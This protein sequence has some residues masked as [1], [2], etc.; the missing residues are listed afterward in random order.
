MKKVTEGEY[1]KAKAIINAYV[2]QLEDELYYR[3]IGINTSM[4]LIKDLDIS[5]RGLNILLKTA[6]RL[7]TGIDLHKIRDTFKVHDLRYMRVSDLKITLGSSNLIVE[8]IKQA[9]LEKGITLT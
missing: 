9:F 4:S 5:V 2:K 7:H 3:N 6:G 8:Q 1:K